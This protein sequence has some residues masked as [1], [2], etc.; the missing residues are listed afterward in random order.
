MLILPLTIALAFMPTPFIAKA[1]EQRVRK[2]LTVCAM[3]ERS[4]KAHAKRKFGWD[5]KCKCATNG[6]RCERNY[7][8]AKKKIYKCACVKSAPCNVKVC[9][10][11]ELIAP[12]KA[13]YKCAKEKKKKKVSCSCVKSSK[14]GKYSH[15]Y[16]CHC[17]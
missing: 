16:L 9:S 3:Y 10:I 15:W 12:W 2:V 1:G 5:A 6:V 7:R 8:G 17:P 14:C 11:S 4:A 13:S